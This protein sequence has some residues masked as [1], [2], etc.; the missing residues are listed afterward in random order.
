[1]AFRGDGKEGAG[2]L[3]LI[4]RFREGDNRWQE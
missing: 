1:M 4:Y 3:H 2:I